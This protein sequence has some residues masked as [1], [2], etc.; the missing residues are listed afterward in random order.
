MDRKSIRSLGVQ[1]FRG[2]GVLISPEGSNN[3]S[4][5]NVQE[6]RSSEVQ[7]FLSRLKARM[8]IRK[9]MFRSLEVQEFRSFWG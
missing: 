5:A 3:Y 7:E 2:L 1:E 8:I 6:F 4:Q 9:R